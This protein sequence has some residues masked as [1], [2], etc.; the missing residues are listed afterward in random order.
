MSKRDYPQPMCAECGL[1]VSYDADNYTPFGSQGY[2]GLE[3]LDPEYLC[4]EH[5]EAEYEK[6]LK[7]YK[8]GYRS[9]NWNKSRAETRAAKK[10]GLE[11]VHSSGY[12]DLRTEQDIHYGY[13]KKSEKRFYEPYLDWHKEH[14]RHDFC[15]PVAG[16]GE[17]RV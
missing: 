5:S 7:S 4:A 13:I 12:V 1:F 16:V 8:D 14:P 17:S 10:A 15:L 3:P 11:W 9:G 2:D 6:L